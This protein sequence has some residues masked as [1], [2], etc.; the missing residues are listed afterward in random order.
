MGARKTGRRLGSLRRERKKTC[1]DYITGRPTTE[2]I[3]PPF[4]SVWSSP[5]FKFFSFLSFQF[6]YRKAVLL[7]FLLSLA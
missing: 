7:Q 6:L 1:F 2:K 5:S 4:A 3:P